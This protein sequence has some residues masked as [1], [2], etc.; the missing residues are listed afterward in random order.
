MYR[1]DLIRSEVLVKYLLQRIRVCRCVVSHQA[2]TLAHLTPH[3]FLVGHLVIAS[4]LD[5]VFKQLEEV[6][7]DISHLGL[8]IEMGTA[9]LMEGAQIL[10]ELLIFGGPID[11]MLDRGFRWGHPGA[12]R[13]G[14]GAAGDAIVYITGLL[15]CRRCRMPGAF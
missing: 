4:V 1:L 8:W 11:G 14:T 9:L 2:Q 3:E 13:Y 12:L 5:D 6:N 7:R 15:Q 10:D